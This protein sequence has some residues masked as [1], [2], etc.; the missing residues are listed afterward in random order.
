VIHTVVP[1][2][3]D[4]LG[5]CYRAA[6]DQAA[7]LDC[8]S[9]AVPALRAGAGVHPYRVAVAAYDAAVG[10]PIPDIRFWLADDDTYASFDQARL[11]RNPPLRA[12]RR[13]DWK[14]EPDPP[15]RALDFE[16]TLD[17]GVAAMLALGTVPEEA[18]ASAFTAPSATPPPRSIRATTRKRPTF[19]ATSP[20]GSPAEADDRHGM[21]HGAARRANRQPA[22]VRRSTSS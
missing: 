17:P 22:G 7:A 5:A 1:A 9:V 2:D 14:T 15:L 8:R 21:S 16:Q 3:E 4:K 18:P 11:F 6:F 13:D 10:S 19:S 20:A 12:A